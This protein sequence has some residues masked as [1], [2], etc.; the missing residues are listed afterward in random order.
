MDGWHVLLQALLDRRFGYWEILGHD[1]IE[2]LVKDEDA[3][4]QELR[5]RKKK[6]RSVLAL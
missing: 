4:V 3:D 5:G 6:V 2:S 1:E